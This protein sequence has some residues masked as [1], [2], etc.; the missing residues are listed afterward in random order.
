M[1][2]LSQSLQVQIKEPRLRLAGIDCKLG[3]DLTDWQRLAYQSQTHLQGKLNE[4][5]L[6]LRHRSTPEKRQ[7]VYELE[8]LLREH[9]SHYRDEARG[10]DSGVEVGDQ[11]WQDV[12][13]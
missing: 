2:A 5:V 1:E 7:K 8:S 12:D 3:E 10:L 4:A 11:S 6:D 9:P 13:V